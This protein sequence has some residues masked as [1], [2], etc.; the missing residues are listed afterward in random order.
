MSD[1]EVKTMMTCLFDN[2]E[3]FLQKGQQSVLP[4]SP[5]MF[6]AVDFL[7]KV[8]SL[9]SGILQHDSILVYTALS[10]M[11]IGYKTNTMSQHASHLTHRIF[12]CS[13]SKSLEGC[14]F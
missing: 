1:L 5:A 14:Y 3:L 12:L 2:K 7:E 13:Q 4:S 8:F 6:M 9:T 11:T 10:S